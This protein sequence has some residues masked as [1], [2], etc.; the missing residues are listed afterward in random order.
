MRHAPCSKS[1]VRPKNTNRRPI[2][3]QVRGRGVSGEASMK[4]SASRE[5]YTYWDDRR[6]QRSAPERS[7]I[8]PGAI[9][10]VLSDSFILAAG[11]TATGCPFRLAGTRVCAL[12]GRELKGESFVELW[13]AAVRRTIADLLAI[14]V[15]EGV[16]T[17]AGVLGTQ[18]CRRSDRTRA[19]AAAAL[20]APAGARPRHRYVGAAQTAIVAR[21]LTDWSTWTGQPPPRRSGHSFALH[22]AIYVGAKPT[23]PYC[24]RRRP[25]VIEA[26]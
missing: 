6:G 22:T 20:F 8:E 3:G 11:D 14:L 4:H 25:F 13:D 16:G 2:Q 5:L 21:R 15:D 26:D 10:H 7:D 19:V 12:F 9:R 18:R 1:A 23:G 17:V 24:S